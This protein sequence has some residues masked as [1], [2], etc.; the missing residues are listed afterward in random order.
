LT[1]GG[2]EASVEDGRLN[3]RREGRHRK[4]VEAVQQ[5]SFSAAWAAARGQRVLYVTERAVFE[6][7]PVGLE[8][9]EVAPG[10]DVRRDVL[11]QMAFRPRVR[12][13]LA[14][15]DASLFGESR[16]GLGLREQAP[17]HAAGEL[18]AVTGDGRAR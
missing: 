7:G 4:F 1:A 3:I 17:G 18:V 10:V 2:L 13:P 14:Q 15:M 11:E 16:I 6:L 8:L 12:E 5:R 9:V